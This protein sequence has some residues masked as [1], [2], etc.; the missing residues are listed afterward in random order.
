M[1]CIL[2]ILH[3]DSED[4]S[5]AVAYFTHDQPTTWHLEKHQCMYA[6]ESALMSDGSRGMGHNHPASPPVG[7]ITSSQHYF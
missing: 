3:S 6:S 2:H 4:R 7:H 5:K 1:N